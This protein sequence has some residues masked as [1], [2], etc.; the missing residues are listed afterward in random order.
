MY[1]LPCEPALRGEEGAGAGINPLEDP[2]RYFSQGGWV[3]RHKA[4]PTLPADL[5]KVRGAIAPNQGWLSFLPSE[6]GI[7]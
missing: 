1:L 4:G 6:L 5:E 7:T 3:S 2:E